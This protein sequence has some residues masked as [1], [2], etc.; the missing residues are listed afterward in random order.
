ME[1]PDRRKSRIPRFD[2]DIVMKNRA[3]AHRESCVSNS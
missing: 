2:Y 1:K 3:R